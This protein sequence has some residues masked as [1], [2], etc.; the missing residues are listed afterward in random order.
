MI[1]IVSYGEDEIMECAE[2]FTMS[3]KA[4][5]LL[6]AGF[7]VNCFCRESAKASVL[8]EEVYTSPWFKVCIGEMYGKSFLSDLASFHKELSSVARDFSL[9]SYSQLL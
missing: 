4:L 3:K 8:F 1:L 5:Y 2:W 9:E 7:G 6:R